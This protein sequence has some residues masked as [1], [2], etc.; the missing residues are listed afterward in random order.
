MV[1]EIGREI[2]DANAVVWIDFAAP[3]GGKHRLFLHVKPGAA[4]LIGRRGR[5]GE[6]GERLA[7]WLSRAHPLHDL[8]GLRFQ[9]RPIAE[10]ELGIKPGTGCVV[11]LRAQSH[12]GV[13]S[14]KGLVEKLQIAEAIT[15]SEPR[16]GKI[17]IDGER[18]VDTLQRVLAAAESEQR[19]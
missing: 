4:Q 3:N 6:K 5:Y 18:L 10:M 9:V 19:L 17:G 14:R 1:M 13:I 12:C 15:A 7:R 8:R 16:F 2:G 11:Q